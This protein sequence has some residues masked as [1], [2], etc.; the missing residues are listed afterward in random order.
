[1]TFALSSILFKTSSLVLASHIKIKKLFKQ[2]SYTSGNI[3][4]LLRE[5]VNK[6]LQF[7]IKKQKHY[8]FRLLLLLLLNDH[9]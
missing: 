4:N 7:F 9:Y 1:M 2:K 3:L 8:L 5:K 6:L